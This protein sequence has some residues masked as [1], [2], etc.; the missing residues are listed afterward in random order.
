MYISADRMDGMKDD[1][2]YGAPDLVVEVLSPS[3]AFRD[4]QTK[5]VV[6]IR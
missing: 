4:R 2:F 1:G 3:T 5:R 6:L